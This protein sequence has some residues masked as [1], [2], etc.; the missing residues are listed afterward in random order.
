[1]PAAPWATRTPAPVSE[2]SLPRRGDG[3]VLPVAEI[4]V[5]RGDLGAVPEES[6]GNA[7]AAYPERIRNRATV[8]A[9]CGEARAPTPPRWHAG[10]FSAK[11][12][13]AWPCPEPVPRAAATRP[14]H[15]RVG[16]VRNQQVPAGSAGRSPRRPVRTGPAGHGMC[17]PHPEPYRFP[18]RRH[19]RVPG[20][21]DMYRAVG[22]RGEPYHGSPFPVPRPDNPMS[23]GMASS[24][25]TRR[26][27]RSTALSRSPLSRPLCR[28][29]PR[30]T[31]GWGVR[32]CGSGYPFRHPAA[33]HRR[34]RTV[35][36]VGNGRHRRGPA[37]AAPARQRPRRTV[38]GSAGAAPER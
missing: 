28:P 31:S 10:P 32:P 17:G 24:T 5:D 7:V 25:M 15:V 19:A 11:P 38:R 4:P 30:R 26:H 35:D 22:L 3:G 14:V 23:G 13:P 20:S 18:H 8:P 29:R 6:V 27:S 9:G 2:R 12:L 1:M 16:S 36:Q 37:Q 33:G 34:S 21:I